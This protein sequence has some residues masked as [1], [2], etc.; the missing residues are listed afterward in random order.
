MKLI[1]ECRM[2]PPKVWKTGAVVSTYPRPLLVIEGDEG[3]LDGI[4]EPVTWLTSQDF[5]GLVTPS[6]INAVAFKTATSLLS[7]NYTPNPDV[8]SFDVFNSIGNAILKNCPWK[9]VVVD[10]IT[11]VSDVIL[12]HFFVKNPGL[13]KDARKWA[14]PV[15]LKVKQIMEAFYTLPCHVVFIM[16]TTVNRVTNDEGQVVSST[17]EPV[18][19]SKLRDFLG[20][21]PSQFMYQDQKVVGGKATAYVQTTP[22]AKVRG[23]GCRWPV[24]LP[25]EISPPTFTAIYGKDA[26]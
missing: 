4:V 10:P 25:S 12:S 6:P 16:H 3:G 7:T 11:A 17:Q 5:T 26:Q 13:M 15:G 24:S 8:K 1:R 9:T 18:I 2:G 23:I 20:S 22:D 21:V 14:A 19:Y